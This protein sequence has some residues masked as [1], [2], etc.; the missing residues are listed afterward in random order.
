MTLSR[1]KK[2]RTPGSDPRAAWLEAKNLFGGQYIA[3]AAKMTPQA[4]YNWE[5][6]PAEWCI[7]VE[8]CTGVSRHRLRPDIYGEAAVSLADVGTSATIAIQMVRL[9]KSLD[10]TLRELSRWDRVPPEYVLRVEKLTGVSRYVLRPDVFGIEPFD[11]NADDEAKA[12]ATQAAENDTDIDG[13][14]SSVAA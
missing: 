8:R 1:P 7:L 11:P 10:L 6:V 3:A 14:G 4:I 5:I 12:Q 9:A 13:N 2:F